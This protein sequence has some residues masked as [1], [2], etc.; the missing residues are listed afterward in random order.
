MPN[1]QPPIH[2]IYT[3]GQRGATIQ[4]AYVG[5]EVK[6]YGVIESELQ[7]MSMFNTLSTT[8]FSLSSGSVFCAIGIWAN[9]AFAEKLT[10]AGEILSTFVARGLVGLAI[11]FA[12]LALWARYKRGATWQAI[13]RESKPAIRQ[14][15]DSSD[16]SDF[17][18]VIQ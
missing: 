17:N 15:P 7:S 8:F 2:S 14:A 18:L 11:V 12:G 10:P 1:D 9:A 13:C 4:T 5:R 16:C 3:A 6:V